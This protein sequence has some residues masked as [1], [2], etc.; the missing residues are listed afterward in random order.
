MHGRPDGSIASQRRMRRS[1]FP[2]RASNARIKPTSI[3]QKSLPFHLLI[4]PFSDHSFPT[5]GLTVFSRF[6]HDV[7]VIP[8]I[9]AMRLNGIGSGLLL[10]LLASTS[11]PAAVLLN[12]IHSR[13][14]ETRVSEYH[15]PEI[16]LA[17]QDKARVF[18]EYADYYLSTDGQI[19]WSDTHQLSQYVTGHDPLIDR[20]RQSRAESSL[21]LLTSAVRGKA[22]RVHGP[23]RNPLSASHSSK[24]SIH[25]PAGF[26]SSG[27]NPNPWPDPA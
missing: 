17:H 14:N 2:F 8:R 21:N 16:V 3:P 27:L 22:I 7:A 18:Q 5:P 1:D 19:Y 10:A 9:A 23:S 6:I 11:S 15:E 12:D 24:R 13:L 26:G 20:A 25:L 4:V